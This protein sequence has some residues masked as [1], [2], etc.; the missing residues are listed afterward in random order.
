MI[1][2]AEDNLIISDN[3]PSYQPRGKSWHSTNFYGKHP[4][5][6]G[7]LAMSHFLMATFLGTMLDGS[8]S[9]VNSVQMDAFW[10]MH[11]GEAFNKTDIWSIIAE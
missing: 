5:R 2:F 9:V 6:C 11:I 10:G 8:I 7:S 4:K 3:P 1:D